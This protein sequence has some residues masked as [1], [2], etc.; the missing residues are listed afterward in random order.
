MFTEICQ[1]DKRL[2]H[3]ICGKGKKTITKELTEKVEKGQK[4]SLT[5]DEWTSLHNCRYMNINVHDDSQFFNIGLSRVFGSMPAEKCVE[6]LEK[7]LLQFGLQIDKIFGMTTDGAPVMVKVGKLVEAEHQLCIVHGIQ[8]AVIDVLY[9]KVKKVCSA[10][11]VTHEEQD[12]DGGSDSEEDEE[13]EEDE[14]D[15]GFEVIIETAETEFDLQ[16][17]IQPVVLKVRKVVNLFRRS[18]VQ[19][20]KV[21]QKYVLEEF[22]KNLSLIKDTKARWNSLFDMI[23]RLLA[24]KNCVRK[25]MIDIN[26]NDQFTDDEM[27]LLTQV[28]DALHPIKL[29]VKKL[30][31]RNTDLYSADIALKFIL[32]ELSSQN[33]VLSNALKDSLIARIKQRRTDNSNIFFT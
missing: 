12:D 24:L 28:R 8:L 22:C 33:T 25:A 17:D 6:L 16:D 15:D 9:K 30:C 18:P 4:I 14:E 1:H 11:D 31:S 27:A 21:L 32:D 29:T 23:D 13:Y 2:C 19:N 7:K 26:S 3:T 20:D 5:F 10:S